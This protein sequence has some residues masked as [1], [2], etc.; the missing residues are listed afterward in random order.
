MQSVLRFETGSYLECSSCNDFLM[1]QRAL[2]YF[3]DLADAVVLMYE[4]SA[5]PVQSAAAASSGDSADRKGLTS[6]ELGRRI[7]VKHY[8][9]KMQQNLAHSSA[10]HVLGS[11]CL[12]LNLVVR[13]DSAAGPGPP[14]RTNLVGLCRRPP[15]SSRKR[16]ADIGPPAGMSRRAGMRN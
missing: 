3:Q 8:L 7:K 13:A 12:S 11:A 16:Y 2:N 4:S 6:D 9:L 1:P 15:V 14:A 10:S 5:T